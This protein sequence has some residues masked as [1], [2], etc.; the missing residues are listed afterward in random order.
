M[1]PLRLCLLYRFL[2]CCPV[3]LIPTISNAPMS[4]Q[5]RLTQA[6]ALATLALL[7]MVGLRMGLALHLLARQYSAATLA[8]LYSMFSVLPMLFA[9]RAGRWLD[10]AGPAPLL[11][12]GVTLLFTSVVLAVQDGPLLLWYLVAAMNGCGFMLMMLASQHVTGHCG[13]PE[14]RSENFAHFSLGMS[15]AITLGPL[16]VGWL[17]EWRGFYSACLA[18]LVASGLAA[19]LVGLGKLPA[20]P[21]HAHVDAGA[22]PGTDAGT[23][24]GAPR[25][26]PLWRE[27][28]L[29][30]IFLMST[31]LIA[32]WDGFMFMMPLH[33]QRFDFPPGLTGTLVA[34]FSISTCLV[35]FSLPRLSRRYGTW[36]VLLAG[37]AGSG[38]IFMLLA[39]PLPLAPIMGLAMLLG[40][41]LGNSQ[42]G[43]LALLFQ[44]APATRVGEAIGLRV[45]LCNASQ[46]GAPLLLGPLVAQ[47]GSAAGWGALALPALLGALYLLTRPM[48]Q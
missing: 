35:R 34:L 3:G 6:I 10:R 38:L 17:L 30:A 22:N 16:A 11:R 15:L 18:L 36:R 14:Q 4:T 23:G 21:G 25:P 47:F 2:P 13:P 20:G 7:V 32:C 19:M 12:L 48:R 39:L 40:L 33:G 42:P 45:T 46:V 8:P 43:T 28:G 27:P 9:M 37:L 26:A 24:K 1:H 29:G 41:A 31:L 5:L 44:H